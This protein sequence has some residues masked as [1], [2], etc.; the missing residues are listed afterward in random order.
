[1]S[2]KDTVLFL[3]WCRVV[4]ADLPDI[5]VFENVIGFDVGLL[6]DIL[7]AQYCVQAVEMRL[8]DLDFSGILRPRVYVILARIARVDLDADAFSLVRQLQAGARRQRAAPPAV[9][10]ASEQEVLQ[11][12]NSER[13]ARGMLALGRP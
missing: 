1:M 2:H 6:H 10:A 7:G 8:E 11:E 9:M 5:V 3:A 12:E 13:M 4:L